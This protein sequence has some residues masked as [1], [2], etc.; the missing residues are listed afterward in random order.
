LDDE[1][2]EE[3]KTENLLLIAYCNHFAHVV[4]SDPV[5]ARQRWDFLNSMMIDQMHSSPF[6]RLVFE[7][8]EEM[9]PFLKA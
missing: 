8:K 2:S 3:K 9:I 1:S 5:S 6:N 7:V 4:N